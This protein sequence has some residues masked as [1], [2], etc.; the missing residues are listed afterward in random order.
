MDMRDTMSQKGAHDGGARRADSNEPV[1][2]GCCV[3]HAKFSSHFEI[4][5]VAGVTTLIRQA[6]TWPPSDQ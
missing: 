1:V 4:S 3:G 5:F 6:T 2:G